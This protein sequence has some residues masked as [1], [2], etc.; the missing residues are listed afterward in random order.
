MKKMSAK[1]WIVFF[2]ALALGVLLHF[3]YSW[4]PNPIVALIS[5][6]RESLWEHIKILYIPLLM[7]ALIL[8]RGAPALRASRLL[9]IPVV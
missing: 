6:V 1:P 9:A 5:P 8:G 4:F 7:S 3:L 2:C